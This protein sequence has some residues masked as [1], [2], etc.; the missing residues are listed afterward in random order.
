MYNA[1]G[2][3]GVRHAQDRAARNIATSPLSSSLIK[4]LPPPARLSLQ[5]SASLLRIV[6]TNT[7]RP[8]T[9]TRT[10]PSSTFTMEPTTNGTSS[11]TKTAAVDSGSQGYNAANNRGTPAHRPGEP[12]IKVQAVRSED[13]QPSYAH[14]LGANDDPGDHGWYGSMINTLG[15]IVGTCGAIPG[16]IC[17]PNPFRFVRFTLQ[18]STYC[19]PPHC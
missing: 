2:R 13:L 11:V 17:C 9:V 14:Q 3:H 16:V 6:C 15:S 4:A 12:L 1:L 7:V 10:E 18:C 8:Q 5:S 19:P